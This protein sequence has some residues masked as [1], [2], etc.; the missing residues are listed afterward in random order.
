MIKIEKGQKIVKV[1]II[2]QKEETNNIIVSRPTLL[3]GKTYKLKSPLTDNAFYITINN[4]EIDEKL[5]PFEIFINSKEMTN[6]Q[7]IV[8]MTR[9]ISAIF[10]NNIGKPINSLKFLIEEL[11][12]IFDPSGGYLSKG[13]RIPSLVAEI[14]MIIEEHLVSIGNI[15][16]V[17]VHELD[18]VT[19]NKLEKAK[20]NSEIIKN[21]ALCPECHK[22]SL[23]KME[24][25]NY[26]LSC[27]YSKCS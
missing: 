7:W 26:C 2:K 16:N 25:C 21:A 3:S 11:S 4:I 10:R 9:L 27:N 8:G 22:V 19:K 18:D 24:G 23:V 5:Y 14:G 13:K 12:L 20:E 15:E 17:I 1:E 6:F